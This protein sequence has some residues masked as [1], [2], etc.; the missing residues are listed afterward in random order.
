MSLLATALGLSL[1]GSLPAQF[2][3][4]QKKLPCHVIL[5]SRLNTLQFADGSGQAIQLA[6]APVF[7]L[8][9]IAGM[10][11]VVSGRLSRIV[12]RDLRITRRNG[13]ATTIPTDRP[14][15]IGGRAG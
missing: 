4:Q 12:D 3:Q 10:L 1:L 8:T 9:G 13:E 6:L 11:N 5:R 7:L 15:E 14:R 2:D